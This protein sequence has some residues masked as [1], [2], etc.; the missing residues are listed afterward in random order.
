MLFGVVGE[1]MV[2]TPSGSR[3]IR[4]LAVGDAV[5]AWSQARGR[6]EERR[7]TEVQRGV[8]DHLVRLGTPST[9]LPGV[10]PG[11]Q[12][13][14]AFEDMFR[15][16]GSLSSLAELSVWSGDGLVAEPLTS[17]DEVAA[18]GTPL[19][20]LLTDGDEGTLLLEGVLVRHRVVR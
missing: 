2:R 18:A 13:H 1:T 9:R 7:V 17:S 16:A 19:W 12:V 14:D 11:L 3:A 15:A 4:E 8:G 20:W 10:T 6:I 5:C